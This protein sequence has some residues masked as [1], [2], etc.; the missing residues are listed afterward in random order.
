MRIAGDDA[1]RFSQAGFVHAVL[2]LSG[3]SLLAVSAFAS[4]AL[5]G[6][7]VMT[8][9]AR[10]ASAGEGFV[11]SDGVDGCFRAGSHVRVDSQVMQGA[12]RMTGALPFTGEGAAPAAMRSDV[13]ATTRLRMRPS[14][15]DVFAR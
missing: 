11:S 1:H 2:R 14:P 15:D 13:G 10:C 7:R 9:E 12:A 4:Q 5:A 8:R 6:D 3:A